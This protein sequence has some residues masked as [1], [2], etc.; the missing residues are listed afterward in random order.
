MKVSFLFAAEGRLVAS[1][2]CRQHRSDKSGIQYLYDMLDI[3]LYSTAISQYG[4]LYCT[5]L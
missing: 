5:V 4:V 2:E 1:F 3:G